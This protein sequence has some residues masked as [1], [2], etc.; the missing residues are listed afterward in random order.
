MK[1]KT[2]KAGKI[3]LIVA[4]VI[5]ILI[6]IWLSR[7]IYPRCGYVSNVQTIDEQTK[8]D[9]DNIL[10]E[11]DTK[12]IVGLS[13][14]WNIMQGTNDFGIPIAFAPNNS[15]AWGAN[16]EGCK[17]SMKFVE[18]N[19]MNKDRILIKNGMSNVTFGGVM[20]S[21]GYSL[22]KLDVS[23]KAELCT[24]RFIITVNCDGYPN[25]TTSTNVDLHILK[26]KLFC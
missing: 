19:C 12:L 15:H 24:Q 22:I 17:Y 14:T 23:K 10:A 3:I 20:D 13:H 25:E 6:G 21:I 9:I 4:V 2:G 26:K 7:P 11:S 8:G 18:S 5:V 1:E 16:N